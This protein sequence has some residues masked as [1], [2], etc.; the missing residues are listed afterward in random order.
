MT[1]RITRRQFIQMGGLTGTA[2][3]LSGCTINLQKPEF[4]TPYVVPPE[5]ALPGQNVWYASACRQCP[6][7]CGTIVRVSNGRAHKIEGNPLHPLNYGKLCARGQ[8]GLQVLYNPD[9]LQNAVRQDTRGS[10]KFVPLEWEPALSQVAE[11]L[12]SAKLGSV[13]FYSSL[14]SDSLAAI[15]VPFVKALNSPAAIF[16]DNLGT[17]GGRGTLARVTGQMLGAEPGLP[18]FD[19][20]GSDVVFSFGASLNETWLSPVAY[21]SAYGEMRG[22]PLGKRGYLVQLEPRMS[23]TG[24]VADEWVPIRPGTAGQVA[25]AIGKTMVDQGIGAAQQSSYAPLFAN[26]DV[27]AVAVASGVGI[28]RLEAL[29]RTFGN[30]QRSTAIPGGEVAGQTNGVQSVVA[31]MLL[32]ALVGRLT[33]DDSALFLTP[34]P[35]DPIFA[36]APVAKFA[37]VQALI[38]RMNKGE[39]SVLFV[40]GNPLYELPLAAGFA[41]GLAKVPFVICLNSVVDETA[42]RS[43]LIL[44]DHTYLENW[45]Y[46]MVTPPG[47]RP[48]VSGTQPVVTPLYD[49]RANT[50]VFLD[51][52]Q[53]LGGPVKE[54]LPWKNTVEFMKAAMARLV[55]QDAPYETK[56]A[57]A[58]WA[59]W[60][61]F[62]GWWPQVNAVVTP[63]S[64]P[65]VPAT[66]TVPPADFD[67]AIEQYPYL[68]YPYPSNS[69]GDGSGA[70]QS[71][72]QEAPDP[73]TTAVWD[74][75]VEIN[76][77]TASKLGLQRDDQV[78]IIS[79]YSEIV[80]IVYT[81]HGIRP[82]VVAVP[83]GQGHSQDGRFAANHGANVAAILGSK[84]S[85]DGELAWAATRVK[86]E[87]LG[88]RS[89]LPR[90]E[91]NVGVDR[92]NETKYYP[93]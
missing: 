89:M 66:L 83:L 81:Y 77:E 43:D 51:L 4:L 78:K 92:S 15:A 53:R 71:W 61:Q 63:Q 22:A 14:I 7:G 23:A 1:K 31:V 84:V 8:A 32:N 26:V 35:P 34:P 47:D 2:V 36:G 64:A 3:A 19:V 58:V 29:A 73:M 37:D 41:E 62:G 50:D 59:G 86:L 21:G 85:G 74:T 45:G 42:V 39:V 17:Y 18:F 56:N 10:L 46:Q 68:L 54:A 5:E 6:A 12:K 55:N 65:V 27:H 33:K 40:R 76:P 44:P 24:A 30:T 88:R 70:S 60:R 16:Y 57:N 87:P 52:A 20:A 91:N 9:R 90:I 82:D 13:A 67:G 28:D 48:A 93:G 75:W 38:D 25:M 72:L 80:A 49:T 79:P 69:L 11:R